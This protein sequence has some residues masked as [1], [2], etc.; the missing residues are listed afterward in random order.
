MLEAWEVGGYY[1]KGGR[2]EGTQWGLNGCVSR[3]IKDGCVLRCL[4]DGWIVG[5]A[6]SW[7]N[8]GVFEQ[9]EKQIGRLAEGRLHMHIC[10]PLSQLLPDSLKDSHSFPS[11]WP[12]SFL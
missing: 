9:L 8:V 11:K 10:H 5:W 1:I 4:G 12:R 6:G 3:W 7:G 2:E